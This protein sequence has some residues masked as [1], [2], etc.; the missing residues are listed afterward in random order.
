MYLYS[1][2]TA[3]KTAC[4]IGSMA[5]C[6]FGY[7]ADCT[8]VKTSNAIVSL[9]C[10]TAFVP[11]CRRNAEVQVMTSKDFGTGLA[12]AEEPTFHNVF[13]L[14]VNRSVPKNKAT[15]H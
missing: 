4:C 13:R 12:L 14:P 7:F 8:V 9:N 2:Y 5:G 6:V 3:T 15:L 1:K 11:K 10:Y